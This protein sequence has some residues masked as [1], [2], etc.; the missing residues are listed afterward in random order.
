MTTLAPYK[1]FQGSA[2]YDAGSLFIRVLHIED[3]VST[4]CGT[5]SEVDAAF[6]ELVDDYLETCRE[7]GKE[8][9][10]PFK[11]SFNVRIKPGLHREA[12][13]T[14]EA[15]GLSLNAW[16]EAAISEKLGYKKEEDVSLTTDIKR[17]LE[18][19]VTEPSEKWVIGGKEIVTNLDDFR[20]MM[21]RKQG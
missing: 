18:N 16:I 14:A 11:G 17:A 1:G 2:E 9:N 12:A 4:T 7:I 15:R 5:A 3:A 6:R 10:K 20:E 19:S 13:M 8:P 21:K